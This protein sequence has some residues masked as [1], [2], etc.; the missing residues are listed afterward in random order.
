M[1]ILIALLISI[2]GA[3]IALN[4]L[5]FKKYIRYPKVLTSRITL[6]F[7][8]LL[9]T[10][11]FAIFV[12]FILGTI[13]C[14]GASFLNVTLGLMAFIFFTF[15]N[16]F[17]VFLFDLLLRNKIKARDHV[18]LMIWGA[19]IFVFLI[20]PISSQG[21]KFVINMV[22]QFSPGLENNSCSAW[23][24]VM[25]PLLYAIP[26]MITVNYLFLKRFVNLKKD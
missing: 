5:L 14:K 26:I 4:V 3:F 11:S 24:W 20:G 25:I 1:I 22:N 7:S 15:L 21:Y 18:G 6:F 13:V 23:G 19:L 9:N 16:M 10:I 17:Q 12:F 2:I 8:S